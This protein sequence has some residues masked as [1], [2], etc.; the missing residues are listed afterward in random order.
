VVWWTNIRYYLVRLDPPQAG[1][2]DRK[3][4]RT[5]FRMRAGIFKSLRSAVELLLSAATDFAGAG[6]ACRSAIGADAFSCC[7]GFEYA[8]G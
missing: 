5:L 2:C 8:E 4:T 3:K 1:G 7:A 6:A